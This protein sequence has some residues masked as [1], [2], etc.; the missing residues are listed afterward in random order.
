M[1]QLIFEFFIEVAEF[2]LSGDWKDI[3]GWREKR[4]KQREAYRLRKQK[5]RKERQRR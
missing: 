4:R 3:R 1:F 5:R 2:L